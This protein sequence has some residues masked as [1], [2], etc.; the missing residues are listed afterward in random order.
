[1]LEG[2]RTMRLI[3]YQTAWTICT[4]QAGPTSG[5]AFVMAATPKQAKT[6]TEQAIRNTYAG[7]AEVILHRPLKREP[8]Y[9]WPGKYIDAASNIEQGG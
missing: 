9:L 5:S 8:C 3:S 6:I 7:L 2:E 4:E 1:M